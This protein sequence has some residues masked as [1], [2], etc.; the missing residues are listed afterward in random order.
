MNNIYQPE[1]LSRWDRWFNRYK[2]IPVKQGR[3]T[4]TEQMTHNGVRYGPVHEF[5]RNYVEY[6]VVDRL[7]GGYTIK[8]EYI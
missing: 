4:W 5:N 2:K 7:T 6:H 3:E 8:K 1:K